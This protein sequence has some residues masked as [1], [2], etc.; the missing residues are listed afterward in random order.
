[1]SVQIQRAIERYGLI[2]VP[3]FGRIYAYEMDG[4]GHANLMDDANIPSLLSIPYFG[5]VGVQ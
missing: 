5:Y 2:N 3:G 1:M 4:Y